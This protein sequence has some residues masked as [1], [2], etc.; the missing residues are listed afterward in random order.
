[1]SILSMPFDRFGLRHERRLAEPGLG[2]SFRERRKSIP[3]GS[4][5]NIHVLHGLERT[6]PTQ[7]P[8]RRCPVH[9]FGAGG[10][11]TAPQCLHV[12][13]SRLAKK[14]S[15]SGASCVSMFSSSKY[16]E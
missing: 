2:R 13:L 4:G 16:S 10:C 15:K 6:C 12:R 1:M 8:K 5:Q 14:R 3:G 11:M 9:D 7:T